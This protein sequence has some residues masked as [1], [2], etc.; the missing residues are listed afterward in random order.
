[1]GKQKP[2]NQLSEAEIRAVYGQGEDAVV[3]LVSQLM[4]RLI[5]LEAEVKELKGRLGKN[6]HNSSK[7]PSGDGFGKRTRS[8]RRKSEKPSGGQ[9]NHPG[10]TLEWCSTPDFIEKHNVDSCSGCGHSLVAV[11]VDEVLAR[12]VFDIPPLELLVTEHQ[13]AVK[14]CPG[15]GQTSQGRFP[16]EA[17]NVV[18]YGPRL[19]G[20]MVYLMEQQLLPSHRTCECLSDLFGVSVSEGTLYNTRAQCSELVAPPREGDYTSDSSR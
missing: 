7:P 13:V 6:S 2:N 9:P 17:S 8:L 1:M 19:R 14:G 3:S 4:S 20:T 5:Q 15:C 10:Q 16:F 18:Q 11:P 12:Q